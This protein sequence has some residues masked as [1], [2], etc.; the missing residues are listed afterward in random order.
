MKL[1]SACLVG[2]KC[3]YDGRDRTDPALAA[4]FAAGD[5]MPVCP[6]LLGG[7]GLPRSPAEIVGGAGAEVLDG[8]ARV[9]D[10]E[11]RDVS[12]A[13]VAGAEATLALARSCG[14][15]EAL[16]AERSPSCGVGEVYDGSFSSRTRP[17]D[18]AAAALLARNGIRITRVR[19]PDGGRR[20]EA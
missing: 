3:R 13:F 16:L 10:R 4:A 17:G 5:L 11:G 18:G 20:G 15:D 7:L 12:A 1:V 19:R 6:E 14:A 8:K 2:V 9:V